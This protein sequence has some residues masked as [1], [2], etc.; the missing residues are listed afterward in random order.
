[1]GRLILTP[2]VTA[3]GIVFAFFSITA[4]TAVF[5]LSLRAV[6]QTSLPWARLLW[7]FPVIT[8]IGCIP[9]TFAGAGVR[10]AAALAFLGLYGVPP[11]ECVAA[12]LLTLAPKLAWGVI[13]AAVLAREESLHSKHAGEPLPQTVSVVISTLNDTATLPETI[14]RA[15]ANLEV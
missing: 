11:G 7:T 8:L 15:R 13:G 3:P 5:G 9:F 14:Q 1:A 12:A 10:E 2:K 4:L 6:S